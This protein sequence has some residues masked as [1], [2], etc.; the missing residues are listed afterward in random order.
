[1][2]RAHLVGDILKDNDFLLAVRNEMAKIAARS[3]LNYNVVAFAYNNTHEPCALRRFLIDLYA[4]TGSMGQ[5]FMVKSKKPGGE[6]Y[7]RAQLA[8]EGHFESL[9]GIHKP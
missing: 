6:E 3:G 4:L 9:G 8:G 2:L 7:V 5:S 1:M